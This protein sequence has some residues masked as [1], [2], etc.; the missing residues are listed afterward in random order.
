MS[1]RMRVPITVVPGNL[2]DEQI[3]ALS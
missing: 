3:A 1:G 2:S